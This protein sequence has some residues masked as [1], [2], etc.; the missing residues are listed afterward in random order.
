MA[1]YTSTTSMPGWAQPY[2]QSYLQRAQQTADMPYQPYQQPR[3][4]GFTP[5]QD[6][7]LQATAQRA[8]DGSPLMQ[9]AN[10]ALMGQMS[11]QPGGATVNPYMAQPGQTNPHLQSQIDMAQGDV[12]RNWNQVAVPA[13]DTAAS[14]SGSFGNQ[15]ISTMAAQGASD[16]QRN[17]G[18]IS[19][20]MRF[21]DYTTQQQLAEQFAGRNDAMLNS[22]QNRILAALGLAPQFAQQD[23]SDLDRLL[24]VGGAVQQQN[25]RQLDDAYSRFAES[26]AYPQQQL[27]VFG[28]ALSR[29]VGNSSSTTQTA[30]EPNTAA[31]AIGGALTF[32]QLYKLLGG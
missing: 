14:R 26:R 9:G 5:W 10:T 32:A 29:A 20:R 21:N 7:A 19:S 3:V 28:N 6:Q 4:A 13:F 31:Q 8:A 15:N 27:D 1:E 16:M 22:G 12:I 30:P 2:A 24:G 11:Q 25:Q 18:E 17:L 23:Y